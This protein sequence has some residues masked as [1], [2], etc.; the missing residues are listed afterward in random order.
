MHRKHL[1]ARWRRF[2]RRYQITMC[3]FPARRS[4]KCFFLRDGETYE[5]VNGAALGRSVFRVQE[6]ST[7]MSLTV[8]FL[9]A[10]RNKHRFVPG[11]VPRLPRSSSSLSTSR[12]V[13]AED[14]WAQKAALRLLRMLDVSQNRTCVL[15]RNLRSYALT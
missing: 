4:D 11:C 15:T 3:K 2:V 13:H 1:Q 9:I 6:S 12:G 5:N 7:N 8:F 14:S 10:Y